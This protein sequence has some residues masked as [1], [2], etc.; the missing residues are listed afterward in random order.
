MLASAFSAHAVVISLVPVLC[1]VE[2]AVV[3]VFVVPPAGDFFL[4]F[5]VPSA[6]VVKFTTLSPAVQLIIALTS[7]CE[8]MGHLKFS[9]V[10]VIDFMLVFVFLLE[11]SVKIVLE[12]LLLVVVVWLQVRKCLVELAH[13]H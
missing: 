11:S 8:F 12:L 5:V 7:V 13:E 6:F 4:T 9:F 10:L 1:Q 3:V 2:P